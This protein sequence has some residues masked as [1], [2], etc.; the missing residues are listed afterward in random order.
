MDIKEFCALCVVLFTVWRTWY[1]GLQVARRDIAPALSTWILFLLGVAVSFVF[2]G[3]EEDWD[4]VSGICNTV[5]LFSVTSI[6]VC[7][8]LYGDKA[9][10]FKPWEKYYLGAVACV[11]FYGASTGGLW[12]SSLFGQLLICVGYVSMW[13]KM[14][15]QKRNTE[16]FT[17]W[18]T[19]IP[20][21]IIGMV[22][23][24]VDGNVL[25]AIYALRAMVFVLITLA[26]MIY[27]ELRARRS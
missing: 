5:D 16:S 15:A 6:V 27:Y 9:V 20:A 1:Y 3:L 12:E 22:P 24:F 10:R 13:H 11:V 14:Y 8:C 26:V 17:M 19:F 4:V 2:Y 7:I 18:M 21:D 23:A 25:S